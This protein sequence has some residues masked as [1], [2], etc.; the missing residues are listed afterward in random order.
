MPDLN[1]EPE[2]GAGPELGDAFGSALVDRLAGVTR[3]IV[4]ERNDGFVEVDNADYQDGWDELDQWALDQ[5]ADRVLDV[6]AGMGRASVVLQ[7]RGQ[8]VVALDTSPGAVLA[9]RQRGVREAFTGS[10][11][12]A[13]AGGLAGWF[14]SALLLGNCLSLIGSPESAGAFLTAL[15][16]LLA[17][18]GRVVGTCVD[19]YQ[20]EEQAH[21][22]LHQ[23]NR[24]EGKM[25][26][27]IAIRVR[28]KQQVSPWL[29][30]LIMSPD[31]LADVIA[32]HGWQV[33]ETMPG[34]QYAAVL[35]RR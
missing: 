11:E 8:H 15:G 21:L 12:Q 25:A 4:I 17:A 18:D 32:P 13:A 10:V 20:T 2:H 29:D 35:T 26:G 31:E 9:C 1:A 28:Y 30:W 19:S 7:D 3:P 33:A 16:T 24:R 6:G 14:D 34:V 23:R 22:Q 5:A 27:Q